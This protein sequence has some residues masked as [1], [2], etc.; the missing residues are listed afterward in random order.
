MKS[1][2]SRASFFAELQFNMLFG[3]GVLYVA[4]HVL[5]M[6]LRTRA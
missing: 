3:G 4:W 6:Y 1:N 5:E 2:S